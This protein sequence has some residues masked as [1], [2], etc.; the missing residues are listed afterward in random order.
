MKNRIPFYFAIFC[1]ACGLSLLCI[2]TTTPQLLFSLLPI[3]SGIIF[4]GIDF[5][6]HNK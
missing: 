5:V 3:F 4:L 2:S 1:L 6:N